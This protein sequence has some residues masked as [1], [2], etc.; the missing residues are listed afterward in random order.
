ML[1]YLAAIPM[2]LLFEMPFGNMY[3]YFF[4]NVKI[5]PLPK[6]SYNKTNKK[7]ENN[8]NDVES[9]DQN[10]KEENIR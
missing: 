1:S 3:R 8:V 9:R 5:F 4:R 6:K 10:K 2:T 7:L